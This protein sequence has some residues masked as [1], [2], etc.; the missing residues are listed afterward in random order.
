LS[1]W[2][3]GGK[4]IGYRIDAGHVQGFFDGHARQDAGDGAR[5]QSLTSSRVG[6]PSARCGQQTV[7]FSL[8]LADVLFFGVRKKAKIDQ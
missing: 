7:A 2:H 4:L 8:T 5:Q 1:F 3:I 6:Q